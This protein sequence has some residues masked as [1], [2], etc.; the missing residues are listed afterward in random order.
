MFGLN[1]FWWKGS[2]LV[3]ALGCL[4]LDEI[5]TNFKTCDVD[6]SYYLDGTPKKLCDVKTGYY[7]QLG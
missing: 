4:T 2:C 1:V 5:L 7:F 3:C 6:N